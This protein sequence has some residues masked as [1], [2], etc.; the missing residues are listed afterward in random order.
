MGKKIPLGIAVSAALVTAAVTVSLTYV[1]A[2]DKFNSKVADINE[3]QAMYTKLSEIDREVRQSYAGTINEKKLSDGICAGYIAGLGDTQ[4]KYLTAEKYKEYLNSSGSKN[5]GVGIRTVRDS[6]GNMEVTYVMPNSP[7]E[8]AGVKKGDVVISMDGEEIV[9]ITYGEAINRLDG[10]KGTTVVLGI[11]RNAETSNN[12]KAETQKLSITVTR[13][14]YVRNTLQ[15][16]MINGN[17]AYIKISEFKDSTSDEFTSALS[18]LIKKGAAGIVL[19]LRSNSGGSVGS[20][21]GI[22]D[23]LLPA[24]DTVRY[25]DKD[26]KITTQYT[27]AANEIDL[28]VSVVVDKTT[29]GAAEIVASDIKDFKKGMLVGEKTAGYGKKDE[30]VPLSDGSA[31]IISTADYITLSGKSV[32]DA[33]VE[34]DV[35]KALTEKQKELLDRDGLKEADDPQVQAAVSALIRQGADIKEVSGSTNK[36]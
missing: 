14:E 19:D 34:P 4:G 22:L 35:V 15:S 30:A 17:A 12:A 13:G 8:K 31:V 11:L 7:A 32:S 33:G 10:T 16:S 24:G 27:S 25:K 18:A 23:T 1:Y 20:A 3:R 26:G 21:A 5:I 6:D 29:F 28:P 36:G 9:R 2:M